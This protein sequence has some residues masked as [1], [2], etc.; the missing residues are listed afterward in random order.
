MPE[1]IYLKDITI[2]TTKIEPNLKTATVDYNLEYQLSEPVDDIQCSV[3]IRD[4][5]G[6]TVAD[7]DTC[8]GTIN[9]QNVEFWWPYLMHS[10]P[11]YMYILEAWVHSTTLGDDVYRQPFGCGSF[12]PQFF[13]IETE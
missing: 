11:G 2:V 6:N 9:L 5:I 1:R 12:Y 13:N 10:Q 4:K 8:Q 3:I 7:S